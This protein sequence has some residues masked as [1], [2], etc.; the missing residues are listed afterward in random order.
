[1]PARYTVEK[2]ELSEKFFLLSLEGRAEEAYHKP[3]II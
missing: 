1:M 3:R 2:R